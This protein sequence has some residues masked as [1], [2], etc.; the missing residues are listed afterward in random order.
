MTTALTVTTAAFGRTLATRFVAAMVCAA[1]VGLLTLAASLQADERGVGT[2]EQL[3]F[4]PCTMHALTDV[5]CPSCGMT[6]AFAHAA[7]GRLGAALVTQP[8]G[9]ALAVLVAMAALISG[10]IMVTGRNVARHL[11]PLGRPGVLLGAVGV[12]VAAW[13]YKIIVATGGGGGP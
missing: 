4:P 12:L 13:I 11:R 1:C 5:P 9:A 8:A 10:Y 3:G 7:H 6:T 2:H